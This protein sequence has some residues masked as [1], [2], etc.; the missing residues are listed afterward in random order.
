[1]TIAIIIFQRTSR[2]NWQEDDPVVKDHDD[3]DGERDGD[4]RG[5][6]LVAAVHEMMIIRNKYHTSRFGQLVS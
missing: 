2:G 4:R 3:G 5:T 6:T 1:M